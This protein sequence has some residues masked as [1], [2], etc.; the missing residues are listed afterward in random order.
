MALTTQVFIY[1]CNVSSSKESMKMN[2]I[3]FNPVNHKHIQMG[4]VVGDAFSCGNEM[5]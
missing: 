1:I 3:S 4:K 5:I 2:I